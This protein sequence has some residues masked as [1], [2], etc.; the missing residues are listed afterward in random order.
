MG[1]ISAGLPTMVA[2]LC[3]VL[4]MIEIFLFSLILIRN[5]V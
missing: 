2:K 1:S 4:A 5:R 3:V